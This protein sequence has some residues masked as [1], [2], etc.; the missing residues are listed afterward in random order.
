MRR[1][2]QAFLYLLGMVAVAA[3]L[4]TVLTGASTVLDGGP[5]TPSL[6]S[7]LRFY[8]AWYVGAGVFVLRA[9]RRPEAHRGVILAVAA[10]FGLA[11]TGRAISWATVGRPSALAVALMAVEYLIALGLPPWQA[12]VRRSLRCGVDIS[13]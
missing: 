2:L 7:E 6:D 13:Q 11:A 12:A 1:A 8:A 5:A 4:L 10:A 9:A 3:G